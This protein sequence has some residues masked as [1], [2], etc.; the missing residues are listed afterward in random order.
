[1]I[2]GIEFG[3]K[4]TGKNGLIRIAA[5]SQKG[6]MEHKYQSGHKW[7]RTGL[8]S[9]KMCSI[10]AQSPRSAGASATQEGKW[11]AGDSGT[12]KHLPGQTGS[13]WLAPVS[14]CSAEMP[15]HCCQILQCGWHSGFLWKVSCSLSVDNYFK[16]VFE[17]CRQNHTLL[18]GGQMP[19]VDHQFATLVL[20]WS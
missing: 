1:M 16:K 3:P 2:W 11:P 5:K 4:D 13:S 17:S 14:C 12:G 6:P 8:S 18:C 9:I 19:A 15:A 20:K 10:F 7:T